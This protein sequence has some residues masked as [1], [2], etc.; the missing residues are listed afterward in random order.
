MGA[1][2][3]RQS[4]ERIVVQLKQHLAKAA[5]VAPVHHS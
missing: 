2:A 4:Q 1:L 3:T 5:F